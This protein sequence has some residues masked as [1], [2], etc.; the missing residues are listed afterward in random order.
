MIALLPQT[1]TFSFAWSVTCF[2]SILLY[3]QQENK[4]KNILNVL[5]IEVYC[6]GEIPS[7]IK[8]KT[9]RHPIS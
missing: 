7:I 9:Q 6:G 4:L 8:D 5:L 3:S 1:N 2:I